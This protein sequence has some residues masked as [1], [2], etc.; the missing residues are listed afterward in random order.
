MLRKIDKSLNH[1]ARLMVQLNGIA[2]LC[3]AII[4]TIDVICR[5]LFSITMAGSDEI[6]GYALAIASVWAYS[7]CLLNR[8]HIRIDVAYNLFPTKIKA[9]FDIIG[10]LV[11]GVFVG[12]LNYRAF[13]VLKETIAFNSVSNTPLQT[14]LWIPQILWVTGFFF[15]SFTVFILTARAIGALLRGDFALIKEIAGLPT[16]TDEV[17]RE[18]RDLV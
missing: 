18:T 2:L 15:L 12:V 6:S 4:V 16:I 8:S 3:V 5:K 1:I 17:D 13:G 9:V 14:P 7:Y 11:L 10:L